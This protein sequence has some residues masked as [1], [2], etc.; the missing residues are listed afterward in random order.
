VEF[1]IQGTETI[2]KVPSHS[3]WQPSSA[4]N[5]NSFES[6]KDVE[7]VDESPSNLHKE[8]AS[9]VTTDGSATNHFD[10]ASLPITLRLLG[11]NDVTAVTRLYCREYTTMPM[12][13]QAFPLFPRRPDIES[14]NAWLDLI[15]LGLLIYFVTRLKT[16]TT[17]VIPWNQMPNDH[18]VIMACTPTL[19]NSISSTDATSLDGSPSNIHS[20]ETDMKVIGAI[21]ISRQPVFP[22]R[23]PLVFPIPIWAKQ[24]F[25]CLFRLD[26]PPQGWITNL[27]VSPEYRGRGISK[28]LVL[29]A[30]GL[31]RQWAPDGVT[32]IHLHCD[33]DPVSGRIPQAL[34]T[35]L[36]YTRQSTTKR[37]SVSPPPPSF[38]FF[39]RTQPQPLPSV[40]TIDGVPLLY[41]QKELNTTSQDSNTRM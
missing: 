3:T 37:A 19:P 16:I 17:G 36:G 2:V 10:N 22:D 24:D 18:V 11:E 21:E 30:E 27:L 33:A 6:R 14:V 34:Y 38:P 39:S 13:D 5:D 41:L 20:S 8:A 40:Y 1:P 9:F 31:A 15:A 4:P 23:L 32:S 35:S 25:C 28:A 7:S 12:P 29:A 26:R